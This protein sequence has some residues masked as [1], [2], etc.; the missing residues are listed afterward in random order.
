MYVHNNKHCVFSYVNIHKQTC[1]H[2]HTQTITV[3]IYADIH[4]DCMAQI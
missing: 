1:I 3:C 2:A 4:F